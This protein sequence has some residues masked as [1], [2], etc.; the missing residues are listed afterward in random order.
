MTRMLCGM[1]RSYSCWR[2]HGLRCGCP[3]FFLLLVLSGSAHSGVVKDYGHF[4]R[5]NLRY[6][7]A[8]RGRRLD[9]R[10][11]ADDW[12]PI[13]IYVHSEQLREDVPNVEDQRYIVDD[14]LQAAVRW[15]S[16]AVR[17]RPVRGHLRL[18][19]HCS[20][21]SARTGACMRVS[22]RFQEC[23]GATIPRDHFRDREYCSGGLLGG[24]QTS[25]GGQG[26]AG[27]DL[28]LYV[29]AKNSGACGGN[30]V[31]YASTCRQDTMD[32]PIAGHLNFCRDHV[33]ARRAWFD[34][35]TT[36]VHEI[37]HVLAFSSTLFAFYRD[38]AG[39]PRTARNSLGLPPAERGFGYRADVGTIARATLP[40]GTLKHYVSL[41]RVVQ[42]A[43]KHY[44]C[45]SLDRVP[46]EEAGGEGSAYSH[47]DDR[48]MRSEIMTPYAGLFPRVSTMTLALLEDSGWYKPDYDYAGVFDFGRGLG[49]GFLTEKCVANGSTSFPDTFCTLTD[50]NSCSRPRS[51]ALRCDRGRF[52]RT[53]CTNCQHDAPLPSRF[54]Y[55][56]DPRLGGTRAT[57]GYCPVWEPFHIPSARISSFC[58]EAPTEDPVRGEAGGA[59]SRCVMDTVISQAYMPLRRPQGS[60]R[61]MRC[62]EDAV[63]IRIG[64]TYWLTCKNSDAGQ[65]KVVSGGGWNGEVICP[66]PEEV[67]RGTGSSSAACMFPGL[68][69]HGRCVCA[70]GAIQEDC[71]AQDVAATRASY[72][73]GLRYPQSEFVLDAGVPLAQSASIRAWPLRASLLS[74]P[75]AVHFSVSPALPEGLRLRATDGALEG[76]PAVPSPRSA[77][78]VRAS[79]AT[80]AATATLFVTVLAS[81]E[82]ERTGTPLPVPTRAPTTSTPASPSPPS[83]PSTPSPSPQSPP[84]APEMPTPV[85]TLPAA[86]EAPETRPP[87]GWEQQRR[88]RFSFA[89]DYAFRDIQSDPGLY[90]FQAAFAIALGDAVGLKIDVVAIA[91]LDDG[92][93]EVEFRPAGTWS[94]I[95]D[96]AEWFVNVL[97]DQDSTLM[98]SDFGRKYLAGDDAQLFWIRA[99]G[100][101][102]KLWPASRTRREFFL[103][104]LVRDWRI[105]VPYIG[106]Y[107]A[108]ASLACS[109]VSYCAE[110]INR[111]GALGRR[112]W[113]TLC[114]TRMASLTDVLAKV[115]AVLAIAAFLVVLGDK[116][117]SWYDLYKRDPEAAAA[118]SIVLLLP[119]W[120]Q[121]IL[122]VSVALFFVALLLCLG[123]HCYVCCL[124]C[125]QRRTGNEGGSGTSS[126]SSVQKCL[127]TTSTAAAMSSAVFTIS[128][129]VSNLWA[130]YAAEAGSTTETVYGELWQFFVLVAVMAV[131][132]LMCSVAARPRRA[133]GGDALRLVAHR[134][135]TPPVAGVVAGPCPAVLGAAAG[136]ADVSTVTGRGEV[137]PEQRDQA[138]TQ[139]L[140]M[141]FEFDAAVAALK[142]HRWDV[143]RAIEASSA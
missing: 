61:Q 137:P 112:A 50:V 123:E 24:C 46:L 86:D 17:V 129:L 107:L 102:S 71:S 36:T 85:P 101:V 121:Y 64:P 28:A 126:V 88:A 142:E 73:F 47:W 127:R 59:S 18:E 82:G 78:T 120:Q 104:S 87:L 54:R 69:K 140:D 130:E 32:R 31:A 98:S 141:G 12:E 45:P 138:V 16:M 68:L 39:A 90:S 92:G 23:G 84:S 33:L 13:R 91:M 2:H 93:T 66:A 43:Q 76:T 53:L 106:M 51:S 35:V 5:T 6:E 9:N 41:P 110:R 99:D 83:T 131:A 15:L 48:A 122:L 70:P 55:F 118:S 136:S 81:A 100:R 37:F 60:C 111:D 1:E 124:R 108:V 27:A 74:G 22:D 30:T 119:M 94:S 29:T 115:L 26:V 38:D 11:A 79:S 7:K 143:R 95:A 72:P 103:T 62:T 125:N 75:T 63:H 40:D 10:G 25:T 58:H 133:R 44:S 19:Q 113:T 34:S 3:C 56:D 80:G 77:F 57:M 97:N 49:C 96:T 135:L 134:E 67:C 117:W 65:R 4:A 52:S 89:L 109:S 105:W 128:I 114:I 42:A 116:A 21:I 8:D 132:I 20:Q 14:L 139:M